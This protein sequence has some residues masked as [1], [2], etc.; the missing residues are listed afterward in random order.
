ME[1]L[2]ATARSFALELVVSMLWA[3]TSLDAALSANHC[4]EG[5]HPSTGSARRLMTSPC[6]PPTI[7]VQVALASGFAAAVASGVA[8][9][10]SAMGGPARPGQLGCHFN[11]AVTLA[12][13]LRR[14]LGPRR[15]LMLVAA[16]LLASIFA[17]VLAMAVVGRSCIEQDFLMLSVDMA[18]PTGRILLQA[19]LTLIVIIVPLWAHEQH[20]YAAVPVLTGFA[21]IAT[22][23][24][25]L[26]QLGHDLPNLLRSFG[27]FVL[28]VRNGSCVWT[29]AVGSLG[30]AL[31]AVV[32]DLALFGGKKEAPEEDCSDM[33]CA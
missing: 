16:Q 32:L 2:G 30:G 29:T 23:L 27:L 28:G 11:P 10:P 6:P 33:D 9:Q 31:V 24:V 26:Q 1:K 14:K 13:A 8:F 21:Y 3:F 5:C 25:G 12:L 19:I 7:G 22:T 17:A 18:P 20:G 4:L 15:A